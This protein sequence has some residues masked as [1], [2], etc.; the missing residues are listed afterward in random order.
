MNHDQGKILTPHNS[1]FVL[2][3]QSSYTRLPHA[4]RAI[5]PIRI[6]ENEHSLKFAWHSAWRMTMVVV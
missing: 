5:Y 4:R 6:K 3:T 1:S 2:C